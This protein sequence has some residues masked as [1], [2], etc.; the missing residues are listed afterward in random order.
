[1]EKLPPETITVDP[2]IIGNIDKT[3]RETLEK[4]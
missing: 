4:E 3:K 1:M 2:N